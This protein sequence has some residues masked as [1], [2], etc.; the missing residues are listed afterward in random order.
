M[1]YVRNQDRPFQMWKGRSFFTGFYGSFYGIFMTVF[2][3]CDLQPMPWFGSM[4]GLDSFVG[5]RV[6]R[7]M[8]GAFV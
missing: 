2:P 1:N 6:R 3:A 4:I 8:C 5:R 7:F